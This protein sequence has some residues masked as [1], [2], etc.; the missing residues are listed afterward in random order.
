MRNVIFCGVGG[1]G[2]VLASKLLAQAALDE[3]R[4]VRAAETIGM[5]QRGG[6]VMSHVRYSTEADERPASSLVPAH[7]ADLIVSFEPGEAVRALPYLGTDG[8][9]ITAAAAQIPVTAALANSP[10]DGSAARAYLEGACGALV[11]D[12]ES[13]CRSCGSPRVV[14]MA[15]MGAAFATGRLGISRASLD[16]AL[17]KLVK[18][19]FLEMNRMAFSLGAEMAGRRWQS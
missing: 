2:I 19:A 17:G 4:D 5:A 15:L 6:S 8:I 1:Q 14:N 12:C 9:V 7:A 11:L 13:V 18:P 16:A 10:Y 3:G